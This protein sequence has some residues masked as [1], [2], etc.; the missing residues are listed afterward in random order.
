M[1]PERL[2]PAQ[3]DIKDSRP[4][5]KSDCYA[6]GMVILEVLSGQIPFTRGCN[7][8]MVM[9]QVVAG[10][11]PGRPQGTEGMWFSDDLWVMLQACWSHQPN[12]RPTVEA[13]LQC[14]EGVPTV[15]Q[16]PHCPH[17]VGRDV[18]INTG[19]LPAVVDSPGMFRHSI[20]NPDSPWS[21]KFRRLGYHLLRVPAS[22]WTHQQPVY[23][24]EVLIRLL[25]KAQVPA[26]HLP[27]LG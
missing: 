16:L 11:R 9:S 18:K 24:P 12:D 20:V 27:C 25:Q 4:T 17:C 6:L 5:D 1:S 8:F 10:E 14:L 19:E 22:W 13:V 7:V 2:N 15:R 21:G 26:S 3:F 23:S